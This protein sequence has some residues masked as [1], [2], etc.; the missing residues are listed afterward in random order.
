MS[1]HFPTTVLQLPISPER[2]QAARETKRDFDQ[3]KNRLKAAI[4]FDTRLSPIDRVI[5]WAIADY[6][7]FRTGCAWAGQ[8]YLAAKLGFSERHIRRITAKLA[9]DNTGW[10]QRELGGPKGHMNYLY[11]PRWDRLPAVEKSTPPPDK[12][13]TPHRTNLTKAE[14]NL[15]A[16][17]SIYNPSRDILSSAINPTAANPQST[18]KPNGRID[19][20]SK[21]VVD[22]GNRDTKITKSA[23]AESRLRFV[24][25]NSKPW[26]A[27]N[28]YFLGRGEPL[29]Q[30]R[31]RLFGGV[32][33]IGIDMPSIFPPNH[34]Q[35]ASVAQSSTAP[36]APKI[37]CSPYL[38]E[39]IRR[40]CVQSP[41]NQLQNKFDRD[42]EPK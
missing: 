18:G 42:R 36:D 21:K 15:S 11:Y 4:M 37:E 26:H 41:G 17:L 30:T 33:R 31:E 40:R 7:N 5:G 16:Y 6:T 1:D 24:L 14:S 35:F 9:D 25:H 12:F 10:F 27:W 39:N 2:A 13:D 8:E 3:T 38:A 20:R 29:K 34:N 19:D 28:D 23:R 22:F 32:P